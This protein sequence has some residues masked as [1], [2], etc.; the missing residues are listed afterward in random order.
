M[1]RR[2]RLFSRLCRSLCF[3][4][5]SPRY[6][7]PDQ[8]EGSGSWHRSR[9]PTSLCCLSCQPWLASSGSPPDESCR[10]V[11]FGERSQPGTPVPSLTPGFSLLSG[12]YSQP[13]GWPRQMGKLVRPGLDCC[14]R[15]SVGW[16]TSLRARSANLERRSRQLRR[17]G[18]HRRH[19]AQRGQRAA[20]QPAGKE[21]E[22]HSRQP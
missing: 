17:L 15:R 13:S 6:T 9:G 4:Y 16:S 7:S 18:L 11:A 5:L 8:I 21:Q 12:R 3:E 22:L 19:D 14:I 20:Q 10:S 2:S 1:A